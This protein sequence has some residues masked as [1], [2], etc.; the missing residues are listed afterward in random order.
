[1]LWV[2]ANASVLPSCS[3]LPKIQN[4]VRSAQITV[5]GNGGQPYVTENTTNTISSAPITLPPM[6]APMPAQAPYIYDNLSVAKTAFPHVSPKTASANQAQKTVKDH[7][8]P[9][10]HTQYHPHSSAS[11][12]TTATWST[13]YAS[14]PPASQNPEYRQMALSPASGQKRSRMEI[15]WVQ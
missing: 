8:L 10:V 1:M 12:T 13:S 11:A 7:K 5:G 14:V 6:P 4:Y 3:Y 15:D 2:S 9:V